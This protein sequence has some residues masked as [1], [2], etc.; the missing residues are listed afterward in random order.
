MTTG[1][2]GGQAAGDALVLDPG[3]LLDQVVAFVGIHDLL[4]VLDHGV[5]FLVVMHRGHAPAAVLH[6][7]V[8]VAG[9]GGAGIA[10]N[11][12]A[13]HVGV[14]AVHVALAVAAAEGDP[15]A[16][17]HAL[18]LAADADGAGI[19]ELRLAHFL[20]IGLARRGEV[21]AR[22]VEAIREASLFQ[23]FAGFLRVVRIRLQIGVVTDAALADFDIALALTEQH[24]LDDRVHVDRVGERLTHAHVVKPRVLGQGVHRDVHVVR[25]DEAGGRDARHFSELLDHRRRHG[26]DPV[27]GA[28]FEGGDARQVFRDHFGDEVFDRWPVFGVPVIVERLEPD[29]V[30]DGAGDEL[31]RPGADRVACRIPRR[32]PFRCSSS[33]SPT[34]SGRPRYTNRRPP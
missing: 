17:F 32:R 33:G 5:E 10:G 21:V 24:G 29:F 27:D 13:P 16:V 19:G 11:A 22:R 30:L 9:P 20:H 34:G 4:Q 15:G 26:V 28:G 1:P 7:G 6:I 31:P 18:H 8:H 2:I 25:R 14:E 23:Q 3:D 12:V